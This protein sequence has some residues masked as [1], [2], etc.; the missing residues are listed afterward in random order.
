MFREIL[1]DGQVWFAGATFFLA[2][3]FALQQFA[4]ES[5][6]ADIFRGI[7]I[8]LAIVAYGLATAFLA[9]RVRPQ[10]SR[11]APARKGRK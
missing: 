4:G 1:K 3:F 2:A 8:G 7:C 11:S 10:P 6:V 5:T 9:R